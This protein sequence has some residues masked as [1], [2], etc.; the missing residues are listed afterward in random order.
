MITIFI[1]IT[2]AGGAA[3]F[4]TFTR[5]LPS[6][7]SLLGSKASIKEGIPIVTT[8]DKVS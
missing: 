7:L 8:L 5:K 6:T 2:K 3:F 4:K 1:T